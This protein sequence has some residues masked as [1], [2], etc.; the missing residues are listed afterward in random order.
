MLANDK[1]K[2]LSITLD[3]D[4]EIPKPFRVNPSRH[5]KRRVIVGPS[6]ATVAPQRQQ[7]RDQAPTARAAISEELSSAQAKIAARA[8]R[9]AKSFGWLNHAA[10]FTPPARNGL[11]SVA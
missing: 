2:G 11:K 8:E 6:D 3:Q 1:A 10:V 7:W 5:V 9:I 4:P